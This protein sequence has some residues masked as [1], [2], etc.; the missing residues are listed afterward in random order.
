MGRRF[1]EFSFSERVVKKA[2]TTGS[3]MEV[4]KIE[5]GFPEDAKIIKAEYVPYKQAI[6]L[7]IESESFE[8]IKDG[9][10]IPNEVIMYRTFNVP[11]LAT[12][13]TE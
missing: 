3:F 6:V 1:K 13:K 11:I 5:T 8:E 4:H 10:V 12:A 2:F 7:T 9:D